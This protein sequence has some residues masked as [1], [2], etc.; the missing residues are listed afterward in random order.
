MIHRLLVC[1]LF[2]VKFFI[3]L[4]ILFMKKFLVLSLLFIAFISSVEAHDFRKADWGMSVS[5]VK[6]VEN[7]E[8]FKET[9]RILVYDGVVAGY[10]CIIYYNFAYDKLIS[11]RYL[12]VEKYEDLNKYVME[13]NRVKNGLS[14]KYGKAIEDDIVWKNDTYRSDFSNWGLAISKD[15]MLFYSSWS[16]D[17]TDIFYT[18][19]GEK[20][21]MDFSIEYYSK[22]LSPLEDR[23]RFKRA[24][25]I[26]SDVGFRKCQWGVSKSYVKDKEKAVLTNENENVLVYNKRIGKFNTMFTYNFTKNKLTTGKYVVI[27]KYSDKMEYVYDYTD[28]QNVL[29]SKYGKAQLD[30]VIWKNDIYRNDFTKRGVAVSEG[31]VEMYTVWNTKNS[32]IT[33]KLSGLSGSVDLEIL[34]R[35]IKYKDYKAK[36]DKIKLLEDL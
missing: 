12:L 23:L 28:I 11:A 3:T 35:S 5:Q 32:I 15:Q 31:Q 30:T 27:N 14:A 21:V 10:K 1:N 6:E 24:L 8:L 25:K 26:F 33:L 7:N 13:Y 9:D 18:L 2:I 36:Y 17:R 20:S 4:Q 34:Y 16:T 22:E 29:I 19:N